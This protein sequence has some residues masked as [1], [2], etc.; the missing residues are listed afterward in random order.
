MMT[1]LDL[2]EH[3]THALRDH[4]LTLGAAVVFLAVVLLL[5]P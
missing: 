5:R 2:D 3:P 4:L 1:S